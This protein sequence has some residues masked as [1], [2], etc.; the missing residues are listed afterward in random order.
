MNRSDVVSR[1]KDHA[2]AL[3]ERGVVGLHLFGST[4]RDEAGPDSDVDL[5][6][7]YDPSTKFS[8]F[9]LADLGLMLEDVL[10]TRVDLTTRDSLHP[11]LKAGIEATAERIL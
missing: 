3:R 10:G 1:L 4:L 6:L 8:L 5:F 11:Q 2:D 7:D 9:D